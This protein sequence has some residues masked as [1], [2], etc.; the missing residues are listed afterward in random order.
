[1]VI[2][3]HVWVGTRVVVLGNANVGKGSIIGACSLIKGSIPNNCV[4]AGV[5][6]KVKKKD[7]AWCRK[8]FA[9]SIGLIP[10]QY[11]DYTNDSIII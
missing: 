1:M 2:S 3:D 9:D 6:A 11:I 8:N 5:P 10:E 4:A 7:I